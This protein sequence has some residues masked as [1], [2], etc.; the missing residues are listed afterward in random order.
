M[1]ELTEAKTTSRKNRMPIDRIHFSR[2]NRIALGAYLS[3][4][5]FAVFLNFPFGN[6]LATHE[7]IVKYG[8]GSCPPQSGSVE[9]ANAL[10]KEQLN[11][12]YTQARE[13]ANEVEQQFLPITE[14]QSGEPIVSWFSPLSHL[15]SFLGVATLLAALWLWVF[16]SS[17]EPQARGEP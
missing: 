14:W 8:R 6:Y 12:I 2:S 15:L 17:P 10:T 9:E 3:V 1:L 13:C 7:V 5:V 11:Q 16:R 4:F